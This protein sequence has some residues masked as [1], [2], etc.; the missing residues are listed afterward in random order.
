MLTKQQRDEWVEVLT[1][2]IC[3]LI[4]AK[5]PKLEKRVRTMRDWIEANVP[6]QE[7]GGDE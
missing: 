5:Y 3:V 1:R 4:V 6:V 2:V 7:G